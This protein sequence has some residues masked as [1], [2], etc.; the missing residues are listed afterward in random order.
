MPN[1]A[2][3]LA[4][5]TFSTRPKDGKE[6]HSLNLSNAEIGAHACQSGVEWI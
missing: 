4:Q 1:D 6:T 5:R 2:M 3:E